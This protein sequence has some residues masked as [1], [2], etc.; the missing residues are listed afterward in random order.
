MKLLIEVPTWLGDAIMAT[1]A[2][3]NILST[4]QNA[5]VTIVGS[6]VSSQLFSKDKRIKNIIV[7]N[8]KKSKFRFFAIYN[9]S[10]HIGKHDI[11]ISFRSSFTSKLLLFLSGTKKR[12]YYEKIDK[13]I[14][15][16]LKY[17]EFINSAL[18]IDKKA[19]DLMLRFKPHWYKKP[20]LGINPGATYGSAKRWYPE[21][22]AKVAS[23]LSNKYDIVIF[24][25]PSEV[26]M[27][28]D[29]EKILIENDVKNYENL[30]GK[31]TI[32]ELIEKIAGLNLFITNDS[33][34]MHIA[35]V[36]KVNTIAIFGP[37]N[38]TE[39]NQWNNPLEN[40]VSKYLECSPCMK[41]TCPLKHHNCM[42]MITAED[43]LELIDK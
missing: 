11:A 1:P 24:G 22:F 13:S 38:F 7:D 33:G 2:I 17:N 32:P 36:Y 18:K 12:F 4:Y 21:E 29:I 6:F 40:I 37:T 41:R 30:A 42:K 19:G 43:V 31:T 10:R 28:N 25:G 35:A 16:V 9:L 20:T 5:E 8:T 14:H 3:E 15:Q 27:A 23:E 34:P 26:E 39:T